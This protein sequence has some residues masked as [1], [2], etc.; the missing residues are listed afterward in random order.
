LHRTE[1]EARAALSQIDRYACGGCCSRRH[2][3]NFIDLAR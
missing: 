2:C 3:L 1:A